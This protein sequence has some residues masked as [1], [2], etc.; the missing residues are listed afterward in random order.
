MNSLDENYPRNGS[1]TEYD[2]DGRTILFKGMYE[3]NVRNG[4][5]MSYKNGKP[6]SSEKEKWIMG[7]S[8]KNFDDSTI[9]NRNSSSSINIMSNDQL[10]FRSY[11]FYSDDIVF[12]FS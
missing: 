2:N 12:V 1:G 6:C 9:E 7:R 11:H 3:D 5:G 10:L 4:M 8:L